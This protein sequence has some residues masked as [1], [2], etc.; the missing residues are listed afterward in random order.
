MTHEEASYDRNITDLRERIADRTRI[1]SSLDEDI[2]DVDVQIRVLEPNL[3]KARQVA[4][5]HPEARVLVSELQTKIEKL[6]AAR[7]ELSERR[8]RSVGIK[9]ATQNTLNELKSRPAVKRFLELQA[10]GVL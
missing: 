6:Q 1:I 8:S 4:L 3:A 9:A 10:I 2:Q 5:A 7:M